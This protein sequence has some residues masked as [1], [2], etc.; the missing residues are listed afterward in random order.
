MGST[1]GRNT[2]LKRENQQRSETKEIDPLWKRE[3]RELPG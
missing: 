3:T 1:K 2:L